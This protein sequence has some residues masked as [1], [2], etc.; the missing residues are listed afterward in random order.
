M[1]PLRLRAKGRTTALPPAG[2]GSQEGSE[3]GSAA[4]VAGLA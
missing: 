4:A 3:E 1:G 2:Q